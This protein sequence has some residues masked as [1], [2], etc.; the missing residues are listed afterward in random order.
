[1]P[2]PCVTD[3][4]KNLGIVDLHLEDSVCILAP[5]AQECVDPY[6]YN[7]T[8]TIRLYSGSISVFLKKKKKGATGRI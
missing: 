1:M 4:L 8:N 7:Q 5:T 2:I 3:N 6:S